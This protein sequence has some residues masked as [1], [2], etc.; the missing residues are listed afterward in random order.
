[1][2]SNTSNIYIL[3]QCVYNVIYTSIRLKNVRI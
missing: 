3:G 1:M 2:H